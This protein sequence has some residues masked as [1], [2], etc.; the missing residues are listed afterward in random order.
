MVVVDSRIEAAQHLTSDEP[1]DKGGSAEPFDV[2]ISAK[3]PK[4]M[5]NADALVMMAESFLGIKPDGSELNQ[6]RDNEITHGRAIEQI[7][8]VNGLGIESETC[9]P[10]WYG[11]PLNLNDIISGLWYVDH[12]PELN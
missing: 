10:N 3:S 8:K 7:N 4:S 6:C 11:D 2:N 5:T 1:V 9:I 12:P